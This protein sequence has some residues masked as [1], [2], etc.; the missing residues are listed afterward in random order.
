LTTGE[1]FRFRWSHEAELHRLVAKVVYFLMRFVPFAVKYGAG[2][3][4]RAN[5]LPYSLVKNGSVVV[6]VGA[7]QDTLHAARSR[8]MYFSLFAGPSGRVIIIEPDHKSVEAFRLVLSQQR[9]ENVVLVPV[10]AWSQQKTLKV[11]VDDA[12]PASSFSE[13]SKQYSD[14]RMKD[15]RVVN[16]PANTV[17]NILA[18]NG[19]GHVDLISITTN[20]A[21]REIL[22]GLQ[23]TIAGGLP[24]ISLARTGENYDKM[25]EA[26]GYKLYAHDDRGYT[27]VRRA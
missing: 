19:I 2:K 4:R 7:P 15:F 9:I 24:Y 8:G 3:R 18:E 27:F 23:R 11:Y 22:D 25:M 12:H 21:E 26:L 6:Q 16:V 1:Y 14:Q 10:G 20:G 5:R 17:D 13:G